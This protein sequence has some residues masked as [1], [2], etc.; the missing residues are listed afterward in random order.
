MKPFIEEVRAEFDSLKSERDALKTEIELLR[1]QVQSWKAEYDTL[2]HEVLTLRHDLIMS[3]DHAESLTAQV[4]RLEPFQQ[5]AAE[6]DKEFL[7]MQDWLIGNAEFDKKTGLIDRAN[8]MKERIRDLVSAESN[9]EELKHEVERL[10]RYSQP[11]PLIDIVR[12]LCE[13]TEILLYQKD[14]DGDGHEQISHALIAGR[15]WL[16]VLAKEKV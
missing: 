7:Q 8:K 16:A 11:W 2:K 1:L 9:V 13:A 3:R 4:K 10:R 5:H 12:K 15:E 14:Y 6:S